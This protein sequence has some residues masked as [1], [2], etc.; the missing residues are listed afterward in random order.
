MVL[1]AGST[2]LRGS[3]MIALPWSDLDG[4]TMEVNVSR[5]R[6]RNRFGNTKTE[7]SRRPVPGGQSRFTLR[8]R[9]FFFLR[10]GSTAQTTQSG[11][12][13]EEEYSGLL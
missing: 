13:V 5:S 7:S 12:P 3:E 11:Q 4:R 8:K 6:A 2:G 9:I 1:L 10:F